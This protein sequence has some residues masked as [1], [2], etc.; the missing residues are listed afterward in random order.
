MPRRKKYIENEDEFD[1]DDRDLEDI[2]RNVDTDDDYGYQLPEE[3]DD[4]LRELDFD[5]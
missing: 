4:G 3:D 5:R 1:T 2:R